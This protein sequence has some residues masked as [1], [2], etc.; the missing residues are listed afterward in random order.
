MMWGSSVAQHHSVT[1]IMLCH[2]DI[3][4]ALS[5]ALLQINLSQCWCYT[6]CL[7][8]SQH[9]CCSWIALIHGLQLVISIT[10][11]LAQTKL[12]PCY[13]NIHSI[14]LLLLSHVPCFVSASRCTAYHAALIL[15][16][17]ALS[18]YCFLKCFALSQHPWRRSCSLS[19]A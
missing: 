15:M 9:Q 14:T 19:C 16:C 1:C 17:L 6:W 2:S 5:C 13:N 18:Q 7:A 3:R 10:S 11:A 12:G 8:L 4:S